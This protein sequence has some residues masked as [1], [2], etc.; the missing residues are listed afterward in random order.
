MSDRDDDLLGWIGAGIVFALMMQ[1][2]PF[3]WAVYAL[4]LWL[5]FLVVQDWW[6]EHELPVGD[7]AVAWALEGENAR[8]DPDEQQQGYSVRG[9]VQNRGAEA[10][11]SA[12][13]KGRLYECPQPD[14]P[15]EHCVPVAESRDDLTLDLKPGFRTHFTVYPS[16]RGA[17]GPNPRV[18]WTLAEVIAD[19]DWKSD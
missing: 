1:V 2:A 19:N 5:G 13:L 4:A 6:S 18:T 8:S 11:E 12:V 15:V 7:P 10:L 17:G 14:D 3:R 16:F 9:W